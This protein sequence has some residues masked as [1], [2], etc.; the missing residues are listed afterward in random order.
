[1]AD[2]PSATF[3]EAPASLRPWML[4]R[5]RWMKGYL[6][7]IIT[8]SQDPSDAL[9]R[10]G[11]GKFFGAV[12]LT[13]GTTMAALGFP[14]FTLAAAV[15]FA[16][17]GMTGASSF[18]EAL[19]SG[20]GLVLFLAG[21][22]GILLPCLAGIRRRGLRHLAPFVLLMPFYYVLVSIAAWRG[23]FELF[24]RRFHWHKTPHGLARTS[25]AGL[26]RSGAQGL[27]PLPRAAA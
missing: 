23:L 4:Q 5:M 10:L 17:G 27:A 25:R 18:R 12:T 2:L 15:E 16:T 26:L 14:V 11:P 24:S 21:I 9:A 19:W 7:T 13:A 1:M 20:I 3:E 8:H 22:P 6:Q